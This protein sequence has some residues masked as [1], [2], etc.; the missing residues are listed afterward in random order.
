MDRSAIYQPPKAYRLTSYFLRV[1][2]RDYFAWWDASF[3]LNRDLHAK[4]C[5]AQRIGGGM[6]WAIFT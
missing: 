1:G 2:Q 4:L 5:D 3:E 6:H